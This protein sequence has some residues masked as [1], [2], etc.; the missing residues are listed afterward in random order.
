MIS[1]RP[2][3]G[4]VMAQRW[5]IFAGALTIFAS[6][7]AVLLWP[8]AQSRPTTIRLAAH[9]NAKQAAPLLACLK[10]YEAQHPGIRVEYRQ[11]SY[12][13]FLQ[14]ILIGRASGSPVDIYNL[15]SVWAPQL[16]ESGALDRPPADAIDLI[17]RDFNPA[18]VHAATIKGRLYGIPTAVSVY[19]LVYNKKLLTA[20]GVAFPPRTWA[21]F[22]RTVAAVTRKNR[23]GNILVG[24]YAYGP[25]TANIVHPFYAEIYAAG[26]SPY[27]SD[28]RQTNLTAPI[29]VSILR[30]QAAMFRRGI[31]SNSVA[32][33]EL[34]SG[35][36]AMAI[37][38]NWQRSSLKESYGT[39][40]DET[41][42]VA[43]IPTDGPGGTMLY[44]FFWGVDADSPLKRQSW[45]LL[46]W[47]NAARPRDGMSCTGRLLNGMGDLTG[48]NHDLALMERD[49]VD[50]FTRQFVAALKSGTAV[51]QPN[52]WRQAEVDRILQFYI[53]SAWAGGMSSEAALAAANAQI[54]AVLN[55][56]PS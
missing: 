46:K 48:N 21:E 49:I 25:S 52:L 2:K 3:V 56:Q 53:E 37:I 39:A 32:V 4:G 26:G 29:P 51:S 36:L 9:Y 7:A 18:T 24:G 20:A 28:L 5:W 43:P 31:V 42:G 41:I 11:V 47:L 16:V 13:D 50:P 6:L 44:S 15:Y 35:S 10:D 19:Q 22:T 34:N 55:E 38:A 54:Q 1:T 45:D 27:S 23:Q 33:R 8:K 17:R 12:A 40:F 30:Q 14:T